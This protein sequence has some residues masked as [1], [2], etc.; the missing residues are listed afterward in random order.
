MG[1][2]RI[3]ACPA[4]VHRRHARRPWPFTAER[5]QVAIENIHP[6]A[7][8]AA[9]L[10]QFKAPGVGIVSPVRVRLEQAREEAS[11]DGLERGDAGADDGDVDFAHGP[12]GH[13]N[14]VLGRVGQDVDEHDP[15]ELESPEEGNDANAVGVV[16]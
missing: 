1:F 10:F 3:N 5:R 13:V 4:F 15:D 8:S 12:E 14:G 9:G 16:G 7:A 2:R 6:R 11:N